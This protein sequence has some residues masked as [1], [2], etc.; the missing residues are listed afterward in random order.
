MDMPGTMEDARQDLQAQLDRYDQDGVTLVNWLTTQDDQV[1][2]LCASR[3][4][5]VLTI[6]EARRVLEG[7][8]CHPHEPEGRCRCLLTV[9]E[10]RS[11]EMP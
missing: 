7:T 8:F 5:K 9:V 6:A 4:K 1:C 3:E 11:D 2:P 10:G